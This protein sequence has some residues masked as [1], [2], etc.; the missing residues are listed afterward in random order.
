MSVFSQ[1]VLNLLKCVCTN[2]VYYCKYHKGI[3]RKII[4]TTVLSTKHLTPEIKLYLIT[5]KCKLWN[6]PSD[7]CEF[8]DP[9]WAF[10]W[11]GGQAISRFILDNPTYV[12]K[13]SVLDVGSGSGACS[14]AAAKAGAKNVTAN[15]IDPV[16]CIA[17]QLNAELNN[18]KIE[19]LTKNI[20]FAESLNWDVIII[21]D[22]FY[23]E[24]LANLL[25]DWLL[26]LSDNRQTIL[27]G[28]PGRYCFKPDNKLLKRLVKLKEYNLTKNSCLEN[29]GFSTTSVWTIN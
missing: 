20:L 27:I 10:Y 25:W 9:F 22:M 13:K 14:I 2:K 7:Q 23:S 19:I 8:E 6:A 1:K 12:K 15:D 4:E 17:A 24:E 16:A 21:G 29:R 26:R 5:E 3:P 28:D 11:P 18:T